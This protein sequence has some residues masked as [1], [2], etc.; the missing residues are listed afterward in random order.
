MEYAQF[1]LNASAILVSFCIILV[2]VAM[3]ASK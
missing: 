3:G 1:T 2:M